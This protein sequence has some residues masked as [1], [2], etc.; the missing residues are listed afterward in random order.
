[1]RRND[2]PNGRERQPKLLASWALDLPGISSPPG[3]R[4]LGRSAIHRS[5]PVGFSLALHPRARANTRVTAN[6]W[7]ASSE[8][9]P[10]RNH[11]SFFIAFFHGYLVYFPSAGSIDVTLIVLVF[12]SSVPVTFTFGIHRPNRNDTPSLLPNT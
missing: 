8:I 12:E 1:M 3:T 6:A 5:T 10:S 2:R 7:I 4:H 9:A 11:P